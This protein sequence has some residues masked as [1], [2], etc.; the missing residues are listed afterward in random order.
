L[1]VERSL[2]RRRRPPSGRPLNH[3]SVRAVVATLADWSVVDA[4]Q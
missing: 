1:F 4:I 2:V 3:P